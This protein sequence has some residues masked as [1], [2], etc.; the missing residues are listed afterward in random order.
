MK[1]IYLAALVSHTIG[2]LLLS[3]ITHASSQSNLATFNFTGNDVINLIDQEQLP[4]QPLNIAIYCQSAINAL[5]KPIATQCFHKENVTNLEEQIESAIL[6]LSFNPA[7]VDDENISVRMNYRVIYQ[8]DEVSRSVQL[9]P[10]LGSLQPKLGV[11]YSEPQEIIAHG[12]FN[13]L[14]T[15]DSFNHSFFEHDYKII[16]AAAAITID[17]KAQK[18]KVIDVVDDE[19]SSQLIK[20]IKSAQFIPGELEGK[21]IAM[22]YLA[23]T[24]SK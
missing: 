8:Q 20:A 1:T 7:N 2:A 5:G 21:S 16:R 23:I 22:K 19:K 12:W 3:Q 4:K 9:I 17:G 24:A 13:R 6:K 10:N 18:V 15:S 14:K 11:N